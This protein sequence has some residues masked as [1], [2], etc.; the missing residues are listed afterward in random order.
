MPQTTGHVIVKYK[1]RSLLVCNQDTSRPFS[2]R[3]ARDLLSLSLPDT[4]FSINSLLP[5]TQFLQL[6]RELCQSMCSLCKSAY[7][8][9]SSSYK[10]AY[11]TGSCHPYL[12]VLNL[13]TSIKT[14][15][16]N[17]VIIKELVIN[18]I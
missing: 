7:T 12:L 10:D 6:Q 17:K 18:I 14:Q 15:F 3:L 5:L 8:Y 1:I 13:T 11:G 16:P 9:N 2:E 4:C